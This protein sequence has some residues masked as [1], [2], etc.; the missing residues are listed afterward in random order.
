MDGYLLARPERCCLV[1]IL[2]TTRDSLIASSKL[3]VDLIFLVLTF[4]MIVLFCVIVIG[5]VCM[6]SI[7]S[8]TSSDN[9]VCIKLK[10]QPYTF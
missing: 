10:N 4:F 1:I 9:Y 8:F 2:C 5:F 3:A 6:C 7:F